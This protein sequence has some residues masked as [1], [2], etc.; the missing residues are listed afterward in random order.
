MM[1]L[2]APLCVAMQRVPFHEIA[3]LIMTSFKDDLCIGKPQRDG[4]FTWN[5]APLPQVLMGINKKN[6]DCFR[7]RPQKVNS[8]NEE[9]VG[10]PV[11]LVIV[12]AKSSV[13]SGQSKPVR[14][15]MTGFSSTIL[16]E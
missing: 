8:I 4:T 12:R 9:L 3:L 16:V 15:K 6:P 1:D 10:V 5:Q 14:L 7:V 13:Q 11:R 2:G